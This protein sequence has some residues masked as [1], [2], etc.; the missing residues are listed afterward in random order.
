M[1]AASSQLTRACFKI[2]SWLGHVLWKGG[3]SPGRS[4]I[5]VIQAPTF[6]VNRRGVDD[7]P[8]GLK[9]EHAGD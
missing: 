1:C 4:V 8:D 5:Q 3:V 9:D 6:A 2:V 7:A